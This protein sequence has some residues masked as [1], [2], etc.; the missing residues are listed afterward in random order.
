VAARSQ[1][2]RAAESLNLLR[3][4]SRREQIESADAQL[5]QAR[6]QLAQAERDRMQVDI[7]RREVEAGEARVDELQAGLNMARLNLEYAELKSP[8]A[9][10][11]LLKSTEAGETVNPGSP[12]VT[13]GDLDDL[14]MNVYVGER[15]VGRLRLGDP[16]SIRVDAHEKE[17]FDGQIVFI[18]QEAEF[19]PRNIQTKEERTKLVYRVK[20]A[21]RNREQKLKP[22]MP[23]DATFRLPAP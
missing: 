9:G 13:I 8:I 22:G 21:I 12:V 1:R 14:W 10:S 11:V 2:D 19:T 15:L 3:E 7:K 20:V 4:G 6:F 23:A 17:S 16:V 5:R 18:S